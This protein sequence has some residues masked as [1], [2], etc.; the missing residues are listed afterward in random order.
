MFLWSFDTSTQNRPGASRT[1]REEELSS[2]CHKVKH[3]VR[4]LSLTMRETMEARS[5][6]NCD[7]KIAPQVSFFSHCCTF[8]YIACCYFHRRYNFFFLRRLL[9][10]FCNVNYFDVSL[11]NFFIGSANEFSPSYYNLFLTVLRIFFYF[12]Y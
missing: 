1:S 3:T 12:W 9:I 5:G 11:V 8:N 10:T 7:N 4:I 2:N 6:Q